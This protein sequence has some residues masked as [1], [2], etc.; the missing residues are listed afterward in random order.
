MTLLPASAPPHR[1]AALAALLLAA[2]AP[3]QVRLPDFGDPSTALLSPASERELGEAFMR[4]VRAQVEIVDDPEIVGYVR[5]LGQRLVSRG[6]GA[7]EPFTFFVV[8]DPAINAFAGPGGYV[9]VHSGLLLA[10]E[11]ES[12]LAAVLAH[13]IAHVTQRHI[14]RSIEAASRSNIPALAGLLAALVIGTQNRDAGTAAAAAVL[15]ARAQRQIDFTRAN[16]READRV[17]MQL[18]NNA[19]FDPNAMPAFF[20]KLQS[21][22]RYYRRPPAFLS[23]HPVTTKRIAE[24]RDRA[25]QLGYRQVPDSPAYAYARARMRVLASADPSATVAYFEARSGER[26]A[27]AARYGLALALVRAGQ[28]ERGRAILTELVRAHPERSFLR[29]ALAEIELSSGQPGR[30]LEIYQDAQRLFPDSPAVVRG[31]V[32]ALLRNGQPGRALAVLERYRQ[33][34]GLDATGYRLLAEAYQRTG[35]DAESKLALAEHLY[36]NGR[37]EQAIRQLELARRGRAGDYYLRARID[38]RLEELQR[39][40]RLRAGH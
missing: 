2:P 18:L 28:P 5:S 27:D 24:A 13:E 35:R 14:A 40:Q 34:R 38:A 22:A 15:G 4:E 7:S 26:V 6:A 31:Y 39:E 17:G 30:A 16:E 20:E 29:L 37:L 33:Q 32:N 19:G 10:S 11:T 25:R 3:A 1:A 12:E 23:T 8:K 9:G 21:A 36:R